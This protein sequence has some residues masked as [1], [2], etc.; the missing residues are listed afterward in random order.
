MNHLKKSSY[1]SSAST[2]GSQ[3]YYTIFAP[4]EKPVMA[5]LIIIHGM[6]EH[7]GRYVE[8][9]SYF[10]DRG[11]AVLT[12]DHPGHGKSV[13]EKKE[14]GF[15]QL[16]NPASK[17][18]GVAE[19]MSKLLHQQYPNVPHFVLG[20]SMG[21]FVTKCLLKDI[22][23]EFNGAVI[24]GTGGPM[25]GISLLKGYFSLANTIAPHSLTY[26]NTIFNKVNIR[27]FKKDQHFNN[28]SW[29]SLS[30]ANRAAFEKDELCG[31]PFTNNAYYALFSVYK[32]ATVRNWSDS[33]HKSFPLL[34][35]SGKDDPIGDFGKGI[36]K[37]IENLQHDK[38]TD[39]SYKLYPKMRH[40]ILNEEI[41]EEVFKEIYVWLQKHL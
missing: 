24:V 31:I 6:Q 13:K 5:T 12:Y 10:A 36:I 39:I 35:I 22:N 8:V 17:L 37:N 38:F 11:F 26:F 32:E 3:I 34:F 14:M 19:A 29:L 30:L 9:A 2:K 33:I 27:H 1:L 7:S 16:H 15:F 28:T 21:S 4:E 23:K 25:F 20:H 40:E 41:K 18:I